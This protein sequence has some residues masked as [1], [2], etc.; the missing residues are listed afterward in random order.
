LLLPLAGLNFETFRI[1]AATNQDLTLKLELQSDQTGMHDH[2]TLTYY[3]PNHNKRQFVSAI[4]VPGL[5]KRFQCLCF[6]CEL[7]IHHAHF[8]N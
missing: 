6:I 2:P 8:H 7:Q 3:K 5:L 1:N 4:N